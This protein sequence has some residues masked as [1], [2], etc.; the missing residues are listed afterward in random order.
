MASEQKSGTAIELTESP[1]GE[2]DGHYSDKEY[3][4]VDSNVPAQYRGTA[5]DRRDMSVLGHKQVLR[6]SDPEICGW[7][8]R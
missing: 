2:R 8:P 1:R 3:E 5:A 4:N 7:T 6:V